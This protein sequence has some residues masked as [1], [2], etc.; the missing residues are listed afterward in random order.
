M[1]RY[2]LDLPGES[3]P[4][5]W[6]PHQGP[7]PER[8]DTRYF[9][10][11]FVVMEPLLAEPDLDVYLTWDWRRL[12]A[13]GDRVVAV[14]LG[15]E[16][17]RLPRYADR[18]RAVF[19]CYGTHPLRGAGGLAQYGIRW[20]RW[21]PSGAGYAL[22]RARGR[23]PAPVVTIPLGTYNQV[24]LPLVPIE[25]RPV[26]LF[27]AGSVEHGPG[28]RHRL[29]SPK[30]RTRREMLNAVERLRG[31]RPGVRAD[32]RVTPSFDASVA[33]SAEENSRGLMDAKVCLAPRGTSVETWRLFEGLRAGCVVIG[34]RLP[35]H[36]FYTGAP[37]LQLDRWSQLDV[38]LDPLLDGSGE[39]GRLHRASLAW[40]QEHCSEQALGR[41]MAKR[42]NELDQVA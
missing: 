14:L 36:P 33:G 29:A 18:V 1:P 6:D 15:D 5:P 24:D 11:A 26:D 38:V 4:R 28:L 21:L 35:P 37:V 41:F 9:G 22:M 27:F 13:Y 10:A 32:I 8:A 30:A 12:P 16:V 31:S 25:Q 34:D 7:H 3:S 39:L 2:F 42:L 17:G 19:K 20:L 40:W 23:D